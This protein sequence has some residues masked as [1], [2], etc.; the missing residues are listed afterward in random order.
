MDIEESDMH[1]GRV[2]T[3]RDREVYEGRL[4]STQA[5]PL[6]HHEFLCS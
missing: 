4:K 2:Y 5:V 3:C 1:V 6:M